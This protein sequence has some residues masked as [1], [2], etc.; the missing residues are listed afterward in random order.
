MATQISDKLLYAILA[1]DAYDRGYG[2]KLTGLSDTI[3][4][5]LGNATVIGSAGDAAAQADGFYAIAYELNGKKIISYRGTDDTS[6]FSGA[7]D[8]W[9]GWVQGAGILST[10]SEDAIRFY[11][12]IAGQSVFEKNPGVVTTGHSLGGGLAGYVG[13]LSNGEAYVY[14]AMPFGAASITRVIKEQMD[15]ANWLTGPAELTAFLTTQLSRFVLMPDADE[16]NY[17][18]VG[19]EVLSGV[20]RAALTL[21]SALEIGVATGLIASHPAYAITAPANGLLAGPW[22]LSVSLE[23]IESKLDPIVT[24]LGAVNLH[25]Q[26]FLAL[27]QYAKDNN[28]SDWQTIAQPLLTGWFATDDAIGKPFGLTNDQMMRQIVY[29]ALDGGETPFGTAAIKALFDDANELGRFYSLTNISGNWNDAGVKS[30][31]AK[32]ITQY[33][34]DLALYK[35]SN[36]TSAEGIFDYEA[37]SNIISVDLRRSSWDFGVSEDTVS[38]FIAQTKA[39]VDKLTTGFLSINEL[40]KVDV[41]VSA[42]QK[43][44][45]IV[46]SLFDIKPTDSAL[47]LSDGLNDKVTG[48]SGDDYIYAYDAGNDVIDGAGGIN[49]AIYKGLVSNYKVV[50]TEA[51]LSITELLS[52]TN[53]TDILKHV[54]QIKFAGQDIGV[55]QVQPVMAMSAMRNVAPASVDAPVMQS[56]SALHKGVTVIY[57]LNSHLTQEIS[58]LYEICFDELPEIEALRYWESQ[59]EAWG[60]DEAAFHKVAQS[61]LTS[62]EFSVINHA[63]TNDEFIDLVYWNGL[64]REATASVHDY[65]LNKLDS[66]VDRAVLMVGI[67]ESPEMAVLIG[68]HANA[69]SGYW[70]A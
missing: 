43:S 20:R 11:E 22:A 62:N 52:G 63:L 30:D 28:Y 55:D 49:T 8:L 13:A 19:G 26:S 7:S 2:A 54:Q 27:L 25:S 69:D 64:E 9:N 41:I 31:L 40:G 12:R 45:A 32:I 61:F 29:T 38:Q 58:A 21:G 6:I 51:G 46:A 33:A 60:D 37:G 65:W 42:A 14:D 23:G 18:S 24:G 70:T 16:V 4:T 56:A 36:A 34:A 10:Q 48:T 35:V 15:Q 1:M 39:F 53:Q 5:K 66:G 68:Q 47:I 67:A 3:G 17:I 50:K 59:V 44:D 57:D